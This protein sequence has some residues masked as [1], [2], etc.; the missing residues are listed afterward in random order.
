MLC[1]V[2]ILQFTAYPSQ[3]Q[4]S[5]DDAAPLPPALIQGS[6]SFQYRDYFIT[7]D[8]YRSSSRTA[9]NQW[10]IDIR[11]ILVDIYVE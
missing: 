6:A 11:G 8:I 1:I 4:H 10:S 7:G 5:A 9:I 2:L 3:E